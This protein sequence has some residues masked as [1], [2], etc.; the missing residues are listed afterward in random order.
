MRQKQSFILL[1]IDNK[2][3]QS[4]WCNEEDI[5]HDHMISLGGK[6][7]VEIYVNAL[8]HRVNLVRPVS[9]KTLLSPLSNLNKARNQLKFEKLN[10]SPHQCVKTDRP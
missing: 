7:A 6:K 8:G 4:T 9:H 5:C 3:N 2:N 1:A 10:S